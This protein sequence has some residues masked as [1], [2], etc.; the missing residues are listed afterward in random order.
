MISSTSNNT[1]CSSSKWLQ[2]KQ[3]KQWLQKIGWPWGWPYD[4]VPWG[5]LCHWGL[6]R[7]SYHCGPW[8]GPY[9]RGLRAPED[10]PP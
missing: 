10:L 5:G 1:V 3:K 2:K 8:G 9:H 4:W 6:W 7:E